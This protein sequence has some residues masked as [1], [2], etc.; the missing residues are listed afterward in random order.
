M[1]DAS[2]CTCHKHARHAIEQQG[3]AIGQQYYWYA[4]SWHGMKNLHGIQEDL[5][6][7]IP[8]SIIS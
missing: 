8:Y 2:T 6:I 1:R 7:N 5:E 4:P 3:E